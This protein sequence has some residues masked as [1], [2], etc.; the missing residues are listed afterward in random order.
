MDG[1]VQLLGT[2]VP[3]LSW[4]KKTMEQAKNLAKGQDGPGQTKVGTGRAGTAK[5]WDGTKGDI[6]EKDVL[7]QE[8][9]F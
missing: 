9:M 5:I 4:D 8:R 6:A 7:K 3:S 1:T 2:E